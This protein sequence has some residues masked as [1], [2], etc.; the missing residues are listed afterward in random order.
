MKLTAC[1]IG[2]LT[3]FFVSAQELVPG[4]Y[5]WDKSPVTQ[6]KTGST[7]KYFPGQVFR[8]RSIP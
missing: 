2:L 7:K 5:Y 4:A 6:T 1:I 3:C 8:F